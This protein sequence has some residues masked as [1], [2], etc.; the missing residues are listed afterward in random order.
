MDNLLPALRQIPFGRILLAFIAGI[1]L[2]NYCPCPARLLLAGA[3]LLSVIW[4]AWLLLPVGFQYRFRWVQGIVLSGMLV[5]TGAAGVWLQSIRNHPAWLGHTYQQGMPLLMQVTEPPVSRPASWR[6]MA[7]VQAMQINGQWMPVTAKLLLYFQKDTV[8]PPVPGT[9]LISSKALQGVSSFNNPGGFNYAAY[10]AR[11]HI[12]HQAY[13][14]T[15]DYQLVGVQAL[16]AYQRILANARQA[17]LD[18][19]HRYIADKQLAGV[20]AALL[21]GYRDELDRELL[22]D[23]AAAGVVHVIAISGMHLAMIY[24]LLCVVLKR[25]KPHRQLRWVHVIITLLVL[26]LFTGLA[27]AVPSITR[28]AVMFSVIVLGQAFYKRHNAFNNLA[29][30]AFLLLVHHPFCLWDIGFQLSYA[31]VAGVM[32]FYQ[33]LYQCMIWQNRMLD[34]IWQLT[35]LTLAAQVLALPVVLYHFHQFPVFFVLSNLFIVPLSGIALYAA[36]VMLAVYWWPWLA[37][38][39]GKLVAWCIAAMNVVVKQ[40]VV[41]PAATTGAVAFNDWQ[42]ALMIAGILSICYSVWLRKKAGW[43]AGAGMLAAVL[44]IDGI[45]L[46]QSRSQKRFVV[47]NIPSATALDFITGTRSYLAGDAVVWQNRELYTRH[48]VPAHTCWR[49]GG[50]ARA[51]ALSAIPVFTFAGKKIAL[52]TTALVPTAANARVV[53]APVSTVANAPAAKARLAAVDV[54]VLGNEAGAQ[55]AELTQ[56]FGC[57]QVVF[58]SS[59]PVWKIEKWKKACNGLHLR[60]HSVPQDGAFVM[61]L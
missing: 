60:F 14:R 27:G 52:V 34:Y 17:V 21:I 35:A 11:Q 54:L 49:V 51:A 3:I 23:Y 25:L 43:M 56:L 59:N 58:D 48:I 33:P 7:Q 2:Q 32:L 18:N 39:T 12:F 42:V 6:V 37:A 57:N 26:W 47:Y 41:M 53:T 28:S 19:I 29:A 13:L 30:S 50:C 44:V 38:L 55:V 31:A 16:P 8:P 4:A 15:K 40:V 22:T 5:V 36:M 61:E 20:A 9:Q 46:W 24:G 45:G 10:C 1:L